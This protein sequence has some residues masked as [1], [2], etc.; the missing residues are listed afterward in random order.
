MQFA[1]KLRR[2]VSHAVDPTRTVAQLAAT[3]EELC[4]VF[5]W[6]EWSQV[7]AWD[8]MKE[9]GRLERSVKLQHAPGIWSVL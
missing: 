2:G 6:T 4:R 5:S 1:W 7:R 9:V 3:H 8:H